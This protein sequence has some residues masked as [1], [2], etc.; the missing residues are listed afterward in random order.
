MAFGSKS[1][2]EWIHNSS[3]IHRQRGHIKETSVTEQSDIL[4]TSRHFVAL[5]NIMY[6][7]YS[8][9]RISV[10]LWPLQQIALIINILLV[11]LEEQAKVITND[12]M[13]W[14][15]LVC[16]DS[17]HS[18]KVVIWVSMFHYGCTH[19][20]FKINIFY[21]FARTVHGKV[22]QYMNIKSIC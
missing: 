6:W 5:H 11:L 14:Y 21:Y 15:Q 7:K 19:K 2:K 4:K 12:Q 17:C 10:P 22:K 8:K 3:R 9:C 1:V 20:Y 13:S 16:Q 18:N